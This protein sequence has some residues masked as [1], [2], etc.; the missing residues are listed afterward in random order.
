LSLIIIYTVLHMIETY[1]CEVCGVI[2]NTKKLIITRGSGNQKKR[3]GVIWSC[4]SCLC[5]IKRE[6]FSTYYT[7]HTGLSCADPSDILPYYAA[8]VRVLC[9]MLLLQAP[10][11][12][13]MSVLAL[14][15]QCK[16]RGKEVLKGLST[17]QQILLDDWLHKQG[18]MK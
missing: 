16:T 11:K 18:A 17:Q 3:L 9:T 7:V 5:N 14:A 15:I 10:R 6:F 1:F 4:M 12:V 8:S 2:A 13:K